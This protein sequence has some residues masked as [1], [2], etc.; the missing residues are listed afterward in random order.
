ML[1]LA[2]LGSPWV[3]SVLRLPRAFQMLPTAKS[4][5]P[6]ESKQLQESG[7][8]RNQQVKPSELQLFR[9]NRCGIWR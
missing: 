8:D 4:E 6:D 7:E 5:V 3:Y 9:A 1:I 2:S